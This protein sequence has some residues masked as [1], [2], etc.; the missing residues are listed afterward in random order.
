MVVELIYALVFL[1]LAA[2][3]V[4]DM[5]TREVP[6][7]LS[8]ALIAAGIGIRCIDSLITLSWQPIIEGL[9]GFGAMLALSMGMFYSGQWGGGDTKLLIG[10]GAMLGLKLDF[11]STLV[12]F[13]INLVIFGALYSMA[14][15]TIL[16]ARHWKKFRMEFSKLLHNHSY[17]LIRKMTTIL[18]AVLLVAIIF[19]NDSLFRL[20]ILLL[21]TLTFASYYIWVGV[22]SIE[23]SCMHKLVDPEKL[24]EG[25][26]IVNDVKVDGKYICGPKDLGI[27]MQQIKKLIALKKRGKIR[28]VLMKEGIPFVP[29]F[30]LA[31]AVTIFLGNIFIWLSLF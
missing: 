18:L 1:A 14:F 7:W 8:Y 13:L 19:I 21:M 12:S 10:I 4:T 22:K 28:K 24:T 16:V 25:D 3:S 5:R 6:D 27:E 2:A 29:S 31:F 20:L 26:W 30:L 23:L 9:F 17:A 15:S 11:S